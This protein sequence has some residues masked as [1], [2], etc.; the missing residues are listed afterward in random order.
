MIN[1]S[2]FPFIRL[3]IPFILGI[4]AAITSGFNFQINL[5]ILVLFLT[6]IGAYV[7]FL[8]KKTGYKFRWLFGVMITVFIFLCGYNL[9]VQK[10]EKF[11]DDHFGKYAGKEVYAVVRIAEQP[12]IK[13]NS[14]KTVVD[15]I[16][17]KDSTGW[18]DTDGKSLVYF[19][20][21]S[22]SSLISYGDL[23]IVNTTFT[24]VR[25][26][27]NPE[28]FDYKK[29][30]SDRFV[31]Q[32]AFIGAE[33]WK[34]SARNSG[35]SI[36]SLAY[37][38]REKILNIL[39]S[40]EIS[41]REYA[42][43]SALLIGYTDK[44]DPELIK[45]Y[46]GTG[47]IHI[48]SVSGM[49]VG[50]IFIFCNFLLFFLDRFR[51]G[52]FIKAILLLSLVWFYALLTGLS[53]CVLRAAAMFSFIIIGK[54]FRQ[55]PNIYNTIAASVMFLLMFNPY[56]ITD[57]GFQLSYLAVIGI[58]AVYPLI[59]KLWLPKYS[60]VEKAWSLIAVSLAAQMITF[61]LALY[62]FGQF[63]NYFLLTNIIAVPL[64]TAII[65]T[66]IIMVA[67]SYFSVLSG[68][69][70]KLLVIMIKILNGSIHT[71]E[72]M[73]FSVSRGIYINT[74]EM[75]ALFIIIVS[76]LYFFVHRR[77]PSLIFGLF[78]LCLVFVSFTI[79]K[80]DHLSQKKIVVYS[81][82]NH[83]AIDFIDGKSNV[84]LADSG[85]ISDV[86]T[87]DFNIRNN[88]NRNGISMTTALTT[89]ENSSF[90]N[91]NLLIR[92]GFIQYYDKKI[93]FVDE[94]IYNQKRIDVDYLIIKNN[95]ALTVSELKSMFN[96]RKLIFDTSNKSYNLQKWIHECRET[97]TDYYSVTESGAFVIEI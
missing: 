81:V 78:V 50:L 16:R 74:F 63:P 8:Y 48:L 56:F 84:L 40:N 20:K 46:S 92:N 37:F 68:L 25:Q 88:W 9:T 26:P 85:I 17:V 67:T 96:F 95:P 57:I 89:N 29:Y 47:A 42:V 38:L 11:S 61:P 4:I 23:L 97:G 19:K 1:W 51:F 15:V 72:S 58:V 80:F 93:A 6:I 77:K 75:V 31:Y 32:Q 90:R 71:I 69:I 18:H 12:E 5:L 39:S 24:D 62:Y 79:K 10:T 65:Y 76:F 2:E 82:K 36:Q 52:K 83:T 45:D 94:A 22:L 21:D 30:L 3:V 55:E 41:G 54:A 27:Q 53:P 86:K 44:I 14:S 49:H 28:Q 34:I 7:F 64:S 13:E 91:D 60:F 43:I 33:N 87:I 35:S 73:P 70:S 59:F 66:G